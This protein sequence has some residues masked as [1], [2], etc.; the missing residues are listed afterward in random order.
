MAAVRTFHK[1]HPDNLLF[2]KRSQTP[3]PA[4]ISASIDL[5]KWDA[6][7]GQQVGREGIG[8]A[9]LIENG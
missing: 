8:I 4:T 7:F 6:G 2:S 5:L 1:I 3:N 9:F